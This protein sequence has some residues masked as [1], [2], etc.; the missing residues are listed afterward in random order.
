[1]FHTQVGRKGADRSVEYFRRNMRHRGSG[2]THGGEMRPG[3]H[4]SR[5]TFEK[6]RQWQK[7]SEK[8]PRVKRKSRMSRGPTY[9]RMFNIIS[10]SAT[11]QMT[12]E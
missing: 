2:S 7:G 1:M 3:T 4:K 12:L 6:I 9:Q 11:D 5:T 8:P 10:P